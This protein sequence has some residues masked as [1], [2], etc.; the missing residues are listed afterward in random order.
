MVVGIALGMVLTLVERRKR[1]RRVQS[2]D[3][4][5]LCYVSGGVRTEVK[6]RLRKDQAIAARRRSSRD[7][8][9]YMAPLSQWNEIEGN[10]IT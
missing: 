2:Q 1:K 5:G 7:F 9:V 4:S 3:L 10:R 8:E 6:V